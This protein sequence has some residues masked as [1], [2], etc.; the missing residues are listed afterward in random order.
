M[1]LFERISKTNV[2][3]FSEPLSPTHQISPGATKNSKSPK[4]KKKNSKA[5]RST[6]G[7]TKPQSAPSSKVSKQIPK[8]QKY[9]ISLPK[10]PKKVGFKES[11]LGKRPNPLPLDLDIT[12]TDEEMDIIEPPTKKR[13]TACF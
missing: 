2:L 5:L 8:S 11:V 12:L 10:I 13:I 9:S 1:S 6:I 4:S 3:S 7:S